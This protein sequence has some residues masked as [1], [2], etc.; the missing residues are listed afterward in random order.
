MSEQ[1]SFCDD[2]CPSTFQSL[3]HALQVCYLLEPTFGNS[4]RGTAQI[5]EPFFT[6]PYSSFGLYTGN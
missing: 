2:T 4:I 6:K 5:K 3:I 1:N